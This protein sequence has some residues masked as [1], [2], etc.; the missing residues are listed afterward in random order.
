[1]LH[2]NQEERKKDK[3]KIEKEGMSNERVR[4]DF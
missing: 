4:E 2:T 1:M 3:G